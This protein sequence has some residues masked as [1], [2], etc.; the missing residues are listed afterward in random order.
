MIRRPDMT[1]QMTT[2]LI[3]TFMVCDDAMVV[4]VTQSRVLSWIKLGNTFED[5]DV[6]R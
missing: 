5:G 1:D 4:V 2:Y 3:I 6:S